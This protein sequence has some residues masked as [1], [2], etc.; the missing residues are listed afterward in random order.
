LTRAARRAALGTL[1][2]VTGLLAYR[3]VVRGACATGAAPSAELCRNCLLRTECDD[4]VTED[5]SR[6]E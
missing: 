6:A 1:L 5:A 4:E 2:G 3:S